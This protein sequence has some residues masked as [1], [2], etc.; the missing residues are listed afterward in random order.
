MQN[1]ETLEFE[2]R[3][4]HASIADYVTVLEQYGENTTVAK[5]ILA[6]QWL[7]VWFRFNRK[8]YFVAAVKLLFWR[9]ALRGKL[10]PTLVEP[11]DTIGM[12]Q[13]ILELYF[14]PDI[15]DLVIS[16]V[17]KKYKIK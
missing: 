8:Q 17:A 13:M 9:L 1:L 5:A 6:E 4:V 11:N 15:V 2:T 12:L 10:D 14:T 3:Q 16:N 7:R